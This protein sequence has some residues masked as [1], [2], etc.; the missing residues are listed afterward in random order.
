MKMADDSQINIRDNKD[1]VI[2]RDNLENSDKI[3]Y[4]HISNA[5]TG[6]I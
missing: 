5:D 4:Y 1:D 3:S 6:A 2:H